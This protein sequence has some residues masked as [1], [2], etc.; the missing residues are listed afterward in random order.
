MKNLRIYER[1]IEQ[2]I[3]IEIANSII[4]YCELIIEN[5]GERIPY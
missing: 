1:E 2:A 4:C 3:L 5:N